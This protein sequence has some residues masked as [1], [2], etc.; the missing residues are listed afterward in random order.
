MFTTI[1]YSRWTGRL[2]RPRPG[3]ALALLPAGEP[4]GRGGA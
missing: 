1:L 3:A 4:D 2:S